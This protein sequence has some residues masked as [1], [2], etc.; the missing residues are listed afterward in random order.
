MEKKPTL[1]LVPRT[2][3][4]VIALAMMIGLLVLPSGT[5]WARGLDEPAPKKPPK[6]IYA[7]FTDNS[8]FDIMAYS[9]KGLNYTRRP[10]SKAS[11]D[12]YAMDAFYIKWY[13]TETI[14]IFAPQGDK[15]W[16]DPLREN[17]Y[18]DRI[19]FCLEPNEE[20]DE[21]RPF[22]NY[23][24]RTPEG[25]DILKK[26]YYADEEVLNFAGRT[27]AYLDRYLPD[28]GSSG[29]V[30]QYAMWVNLGQVA[31]RE[32]LQL[33]K[34]P[35]DHLDNL[36]KP[37]D[38]PE[39]IYDDGTISYIPDGNKTIYSM[40]TEAHLM[41]LRSKNHPDLSFVS[42]GDGSYELKNA[43]G[44]AVPGMYTEIPDGSGAKID[45]KFT[46]PLERD[47]PM[48]N[49]GQ[50][51]LRIRLEKG[52]K[53][54]DI[55]VK[56]IRPNY[57]MDQEWVIY[58]SPEVTLKESE[59]LIG[60]PVTSIID[61]E[62]VVTLSPVEDAGGSSEEDPKT[63]EE[64]PKTSEED[65]KTSEEDPKTSEGDPTTSEEDPKTSEEDPKTSE[66]DPKTSEEDPKSSE[67]D[68]KTSEEDPPKEDPPGGGNTGSDDEKPNDPDKDSNAGKDKE[69]EQPPK[70]QDPDKSGRDKTPSSE[71][72]D[73]DKATPSEGDSPRE[74]M[75]QPGGTFSP[76]GPDGKLKDDWWAY[77][78]YYDP[79]SEDNL[80]KEKSGG[81]RK[82]GSS[83][84]SS[85]SPN[86]GEEMALLPFAFGSGLSGLGLFCL[87]R[88]KKR[89]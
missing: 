8:Y 82:T 76:L 42:L 2:M 47:N 10:K 16:V 18:L 62:D 45:D 52:K 32:K 72:K 39:T 29:Y 22:H 74:W 51:P 13:P 89:K 63:S 35:D 31:E 26:E 64:D 12:F 53:I 56:I 84:K 9:L 20:I 65:P 71:K 79:D 25:L 17:A 77:A 28:D 58:G 41:G 66:E 19:I 21:I 27:D 50:Y 14:G 49:T 48:V 23:R 70:T 60:K 68:P 67:E 11:N 57:A 36:L 59:Q 4:L 40:T 86:T 61:Q 69:P 46:K 85:K 73:P 7:V 54:E 55:P 83:R 80:W 38:L 88:Q 78:K 1:M 75:G 87:V 81:G 3:A 30:R 15:E 34:G 6:T 33:A 24:D 43:K 37:Y 44:F 5:A